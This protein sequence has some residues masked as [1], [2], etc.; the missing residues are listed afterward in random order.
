MWLPH[1][2]TTAATPVGTPT[3][4]FHED[5]G[6]V[7]AVVVTH[8]RPVLL[9]SCLRA[10]RMQRRA[11]DLVIVVDNASGPETAAVI[12]RFEGTRTLRLAENL[13]GAAGFRA[14]IDA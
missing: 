6:P 13:G 3:P 7:V 2:I 14:G 11:P 4:S 12:A 1:D 9:E 10:V 8:D 5:A